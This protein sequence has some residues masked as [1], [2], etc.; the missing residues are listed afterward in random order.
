MPVTIPGTPVKLGGSIDRLDLN[1]RGT[2]VRVWDYKTGQTPRNPARIVIDGGSEL[3]RA[4]YG[5]AC[6][7]LL[8]GEP[9]VVARLLYLRGDTLAVRLP[10]LDAAVEQIAAF[11]NV[12]VSMMRKGVV[13][14]GRLSF[15]RS[16]ELRLALPASPGY[17]RRKLAA[18]NKINATI[19]R[20]WSAP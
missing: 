2:A 12:A 13:T 14:S 15:D 5:L 11:V 19:S 1:S 3:Q 16:N 9:T 20:Y 7:Q 8:D 10:D 6:R 17:E 18:S 4:L